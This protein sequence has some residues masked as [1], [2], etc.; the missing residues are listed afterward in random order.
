MTVE[1][2]KKCN[3]KKVPGTSVIYD[4]NPDFTGTDTFS[5]TVIYSGGQARKFEITVSVEPPTSASAANGTMPNSEPRKIKT[6]DVK[7][8]AAAE[9]GGVP[10][11]AQKVEPPISANA[12]KVKVSVEPP[13]SA[14]AQE[15]KKVEYPAYL[16]SW[17]I[18]R[19]VPK[20][21]NAG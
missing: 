17:Q 4:P 13:I 11:G 9:N 1:D 6:L 15:Q 5:G 14:S 16:P 3:S 19:V 21:K 18:E 2:Y 7:G 12:Q 8:D 10:A 20:V